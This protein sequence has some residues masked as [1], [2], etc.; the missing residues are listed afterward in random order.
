MQ[1][2]ES[3]IFC[4]LGR[5]VFSNNKMVLLLVPWNTGTSKPT[6]LD[7]QRMQKGESNIFCMLGRIVLSKNKMVAIVPRNTGTSK[8]TISDDRRMQKGESNIFCMLGRIIFSNNKMVLYCGILA[9][10]NQQYWTIGECKKENPI[11]FACLDVLYFQTTKWYYCL[12]RGIPARRNQ[13]YW[14]IRECKKENLIS[15]ACLDI[16]VS[17]FLLIVEWMHSYTIA[18]GCFQRNNFTKFQGTHRDAPRY[19]TCQ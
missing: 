11:S 18:T 13:Q 10:R 14:T 7:D 3:D 19:L 4:M 9:R 1:K 2:G 12:Y 8:P 17:Y 15:F 16:Q 5:I 6:I